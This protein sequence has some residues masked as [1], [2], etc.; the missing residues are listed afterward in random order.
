MLDNIIRFY[1]LALNHIGITRLRD[2]I[3][4]HFYHPHLQPNVERVVH[5]C[6]S[7]Q[8]YK[9]PGW[10]H[11][12]LAARTAGITPW[13]EVAVDLIGPWSVSVHGQDLKLNALTSIDTV[14]NYPEI[15][16]INNKKSQ[17]VSQPFENSWLA[18][19]PRS[20]RCIRSRIIIY[21]TWITDNAGQLQYSIP[22]DYSKKSTSQCDLRKTTSN[23]SKRDTPTY[24]C[25][26][27]S[28]YQWCNRNYRHSAQHCRLFS[29]S[30]NIF[31]TQDITR[32][33]S[34]SSRH[35]SR[36]THYRRSTPISAT[37]T[38]PIDYR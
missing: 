24:P 9:V 19:Y 30:S 21:R 25:T 8:R 2:T 13:Q 27:T 34:V 12:H 23:S 5:P 35:A 22:T 6:D 17:Y 31:D 33:S 14:T 28:E 20:V 18:R 29:K 4:L 32:S 1:H 38:A 26:S 11:G 15:I 16:R 37:T 36:H 3:A 10:W 7:C